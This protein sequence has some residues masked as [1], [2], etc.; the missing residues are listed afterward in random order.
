[1]ANPA[2]AAAAAEHL[3]LK[4]WVVMC[5]V[6]LVGAEAVAPASTFTQSLIR[7][8]ALADLWRPP[9]QLRVQLSVRVYFGYRLTVSPKRA[10]TNTGYCYKYVRVVH[11]DAT[12]RLRLQYVWA[13]TEQRIAGMQRSSLPTKRVTAL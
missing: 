11:G 3:A 13:G 4:P 12:F 7:T 2:A 1:M 9:N 6:L 5:L 10:V 8:S